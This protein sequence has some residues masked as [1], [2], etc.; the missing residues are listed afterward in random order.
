MWASNMLCNLF[1]RADCYMIMHFGNM[2]Q[3]VAETAVGNYHS[4]RVVPFLMVSVAGMLGGLILPHLSH[5]WERGRRDVVV[6]QLNLAYKL[7]AIVF[8][9]GSVALLALSPLLFG[10]AL[11]GKYNGGLAVLPWTLAGCLWFALVLIAVN[12]LWC[13]ERVKLVSA[14][15]LCGL[16][17]NVA[18]NWFLL[19]RF[20]LLGAVLATAAGYGFALVLVHL[21]NRRHGMRVPAAVWLVSALPVLVGF[22]LWIG[23]LGLLAVIVLALRTNMLFTNDE[24]LQV[25]EA[26]RGY[27]A[28]ARNMAAALTNRYRNR[29]VPSSPAG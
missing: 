24:R 18:L 4:S 8:L 9:A 15:F 14:C 17:L 19:P 6:G 12:Y 10:W 21:F 16:L 13:A 5:H 1:E 29:V 2:T 26:I 7:A 3:H 11:G 28:R 22:G 25:E 27:V 20:G 23:G